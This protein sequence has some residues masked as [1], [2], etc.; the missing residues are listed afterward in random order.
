MRTFRCLLIALGLAAAVA[1]ARARAVEI[2]PL[3]KTLTEVGPK[4]AGN[5]RA[6]QAWA[7]LAR[8]DAAQLPAMLAAL[9]SAQ[10]LAANWIRS[11][12]D[13]VA[14]R[15]VRAGGKLP[16]AELERF[17]LDT[18]HDSR[19]RR[20]AY[21]WLVRVDP[22]APDR[23]V[24]GML[25]DPSVELRRDAVAQLID[26]AAALAKEVQSAE[27]AKVDGLKSEAAAA[28]RHAFEA[29]R[30]LDQ[31]KLLVARLEDLGQEVDLPRHFGFL[32]RWKVI[33]PF[34]NTG[35]KGYDVVYPPERGID[36]EGSYPGKKG[37]VKWFDHVTGDDYGTVD[38]N[39]V[40]AEEKG[41][42]AYAAAEFASAERQEVEIRMA[43]ADAV[44]LWL[45]GALIDEHNVYHAGGQVDAY[46]SKVVLKP[47]RNVILVKVCQNEQT[48][49]WAGRW[50]LQ[51]RVCDSTGGAILSTNRGG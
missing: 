42:V 40:I 44:K 39:K 51:L 26:E 9:D 33:G 8:S 31:I 13:A 30:D 10:P 27:P 37:S 2:Q 32:L 29:A 14:E 19:A 7:Q 16:L 3:L 36:L 43:S 25:N 6:S 34:D 11:A 47:G 21:E 17:L 15:Q 12:V 1:A 5:S 4:G 24:P 20:L 45:N 46:T 48:Q 23:L 49:N 38:F 50:N 41:V 18:S 22:T 35:E 28:Y